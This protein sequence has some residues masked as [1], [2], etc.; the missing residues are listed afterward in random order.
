MLE[1]VAGLAGVA[2]DLGQAE[3]AAQ[4]LGAVTAMQEVGGIAAVTNDP[5]TQHTLRAAREALGTKAFTA[6]VDVGRGLPWAGAI[7]DA[8]AVLEPKESQ[9]P[10][11][12]D[13]DLPSSFA[14]TRREREVLSL[15]CQRLTDPEIAAQLFISP[16]TA[17]KH[18]SNVLGKLRVANRREAAAVA[19]RHALV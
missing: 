19:V 15:L 12:T 16:Y 13:V 2:M 5:R 8:L 3:R 1:A 9:S 11:L 18:F 6:A 4:L 7:E 14:L 17:S 10:G